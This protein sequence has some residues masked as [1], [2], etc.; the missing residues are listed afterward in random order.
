MNQE[1]QNPILYRNTLTYPKRKQGSQNPRYDI[2]KITNKIIFDILLK[3]SI[4]KER[5]KPE[6]CTEITT[7]GS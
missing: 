4:Q 2:E 5:F 6:I 1:I 3:T 7:K